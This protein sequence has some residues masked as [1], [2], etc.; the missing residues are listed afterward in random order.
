MIKRSQ[1]KYIRIR[2]VVADMFT[3]ELSVT[4][5][6]EISTINDF[7]YLILSNYIKHTR[8]LKFNKSFF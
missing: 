7:I 3:R 2:N 6:T 4:K 5:I 8:N 1:E